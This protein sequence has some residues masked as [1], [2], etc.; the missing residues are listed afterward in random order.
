[1]S[2][3]F[4]KILTAV[5]SAWVNVACGRNIGHANLLLRDGEESGQFLYWLKTVKQKKKWSGVDE[6]LSGMECVHE[7]FCGIQLDDAS[8]TA[9]FKKHSR[10]SSHYATKPGYS[11]PAM[12][13]DSITQSHYFR[14]MIVLMGT[15]RCV[16]I[17]VGHRDANAN[18]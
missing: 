4:A 13:N 8:S 3:H 2:R 14:H 10:T 15:P 12:I 16:L 11:C 18:F 9:E 17:I 5:K 1:M 7:F 6:F